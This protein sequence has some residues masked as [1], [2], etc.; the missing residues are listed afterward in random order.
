MQLAGEP[1]VDVIA[2]RWERGSAFPP[3]EREAGSVQLLRAES[4]CSDMFTYSVGVQLQAQCATVFDDLVL[5]KS[6][7]GDA[8]AAVI[9][10]K[11][12]V[13]MWTC[14]QQGGIESQLSITG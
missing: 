8:S 12:T 1:G 6:Y 7:K 10:G 4:V 9:C 14:G 2:A 3:R 13:F 11:A 5:M